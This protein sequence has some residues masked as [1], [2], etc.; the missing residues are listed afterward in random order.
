MDPSAPDLRRYPRAPGAEPLMSV[1]T[2]K[3][4]RI[5][6]LSALPADPQ[7][8]PAP[9]LAPLPALHLVGGPK[10]ALVRLSP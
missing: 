9:R 1:P 3:F 8:P 7:P 10:L 5:R 4:L 6:Q 2:P